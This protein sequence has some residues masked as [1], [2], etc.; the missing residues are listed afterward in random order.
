MKTNRASSHVNLGKGHGV[1]QVEGIYTHTRTFSVQGSRQA[2]MRYKDTISSE[3]GCVGCP[4]R[5][6]G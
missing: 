4:A 6:V 5:K 2:T 1:S 3:L